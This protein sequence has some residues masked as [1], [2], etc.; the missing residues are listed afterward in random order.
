MSGIFPH[1]HIRH[2]VRVV[3]EGPTD[4]A[5]LL[6]L[7]FQA[8][9]RPSAMGGMRL[10]VEAALKWRPR[11]VVIVA[12]DDGPGQRGAANL[13][14]QAAVYCEVV[15]VITPPGGA[16][17]ARGWKRAGANSAD[18]Q[19]AIEAAKPR[20]LEVALKRKAGRCRKTTV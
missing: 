1:H 3:A 18:L 8:V 2:P 12:D 10:L 7:G 14:R 13:A 11:E 9:G 4:T 16:K 6:D 5:A 15:R 20:R 17:D 19:R